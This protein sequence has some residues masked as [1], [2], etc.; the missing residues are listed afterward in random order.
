[1]I[2]KIIIPARGNSKRIP[3]KNMKFL[4]DKPLIQYSIDYA[5]NNLSAESIWVNSDD[6]M[7]I[8]FAKSIGVKTL[9][10]PDS[11]STDYTP[12]VDVLKFQ[13]NYFKE[14]N[15]RC[16]AII[17]LQPTNPFRDDN[18]LTIAKNKLIDSKRNSLATFSKSNNKIGLI[19]N[20]TFKPINYSPGQRSQDLEKSY[21]EN[22]LLYITKCKSILSGEIITEDAYPLICYDIESTIDIDYPEDFIFAESLL[23]LKSENHDK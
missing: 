21:F 1:M 23:K 2:F 5:L 17:L 18:L 3:G 11:L 15:I 4:G 19:K 6:Q 13:I 10:R 8:E 14:N 20:N 22:G 16:D 7:I 9:L 12:T